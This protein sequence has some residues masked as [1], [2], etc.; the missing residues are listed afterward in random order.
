MSSEQPASDASNGYDGGAPERREIT[1]RRAPKFVPFLVVGGLLGLIA[2]F[3]ITFAVPENPDFTR[4]SVLGFFAVL[5]AL[6]GVLI[7]AL[8]ALLFDFISVRRAKRA[9]VEST[10]DDAD[11]GVAP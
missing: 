2:A 7:G 4:G 10:G 9:T 11:G 5:L 6:P 3:I 1:I 8:A